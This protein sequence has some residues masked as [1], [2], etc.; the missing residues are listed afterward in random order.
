MG[1]GGGGGGVGGIPAHTQL[2][3]ERLGSGWGSV[4]GG[5]D[6]LVT[7]LPLPSWPAGPPDHQ[8]YVYKAITEG[9]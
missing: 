9:K 4:Q 1:W 3:D 5:A 7:G 2:L 8:G 6:C